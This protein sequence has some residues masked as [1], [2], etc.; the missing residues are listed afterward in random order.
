M[1]MQE[2]VNK[3]WNFSNLWLILFDSL[4]SPNIIYINILLYIYFY[5]LANNARNNQ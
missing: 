2:I 4:F 3:I 5:S 1:I